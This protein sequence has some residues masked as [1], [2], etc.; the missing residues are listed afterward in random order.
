MRILLVHN[1]YRKPG[2][3]DA[4]VANEAQLLRG[5]GHMVELFEIEN[6]AED[7]R[8]FGE[9]ISR[10]FNVIWSHTGAQQ[11][12]DQVQL[13]QP[14]VVHFHNTF[15]MLSPAAVRAVRALRVPVAQTVHNY[16][17]IC[18]NGLLMRDGK[19]C[20]VCVEGWRFHGVMNAC[21]RASK[22]ASAAIMAAGTIH[23]WL[24]TF[25]GKGVRLIALTNF[26]KKLLTQAGFDADSIVIK[27]NFV[28][29]AEPSTI[30]SR[31]IVFVGR[32]A[33][34]KGIDTLVNAWVNSGIHAQGWTL[35]VIGDGPLSSIV[36]TAGHG[37]VGIGW[38]SNEEAR[39]RIASARYLVM[40]SKTFEGMPMVALEAL[41]VG[42]PVILPHLGGMGEI[43]SADTCGIGFDA[44]D[45]GAL[46]QALLKA[47]SISNAEWDALGSSA[48]ACF[49]K[50][51]SPAANYK[52]LFS[53][54][55]LL[56]RE[57][58]A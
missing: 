41:S 31:T 22:P 14:D 52:A 53:T 13:F 19:T 28:F 11:V 8:S 23:K 20:T 42:T 36:S 29:P 27:P 9:K 33:E 40:C 16:R 32:L 17:L 15:S 54:Y 4:V 24:N 21:Y 46:Q 34:E 5:N 55:E 37:I 25:S 18:A 6:P 44:N 1:R 7:P 43:I 3:E 10:A 58:R 51:Y 2:G 26:A 45:P 12:R 56:L 38:V 57:M 50:K 30:R 47:S 39:M 35:Q 48:F 49:E